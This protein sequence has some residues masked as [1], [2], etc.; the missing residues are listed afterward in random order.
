MT[1]A[2]TMS[3]DTSGLLRLRENYLFRTICNAR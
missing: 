2:P 1:L 3:E